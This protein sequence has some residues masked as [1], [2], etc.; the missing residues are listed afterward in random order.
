M[1]FS[2]E[3]I[4]PAPRVIAFERLNDPLFFA[5]CLEGVSELEEVDPEH[6]TATLETKVAYVKFRF[7]VAV[8]LVERVAPSRV[9]AKV[10]GTPMGIVG[11]LTATA[12]AELEET[13]DGRE[14]RVRYE[15]DVALAGK[16]GSLGQ[17]VLKAK[18]KEM[19]RGFVEKSSAAFAAEP[20]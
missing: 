10:E 19:E 4:I 3:L 5:A 8:A 17:P 16:L 7:A 12:V 13:D 9:V 6:Y 20:V 2:G 14:T 15:M 11:R 18:A 1:K